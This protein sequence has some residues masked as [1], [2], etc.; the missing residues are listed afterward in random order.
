MSKKLKIII[1]LCVNALIVILGSI[2]ILTQIF[3]TNSNGALSVSGFRVFKYFTNDGNILTIIVSSIIVVMNILELKKNE[4]TKPIWAYYLQ[5][6]SAVSGMIIF[7]VVMF[8]LL[9][10]FGVGIILGYRMMVLHIINP[11]LAV[12]TLIL[13][14]EKNK[15]IS[16]KECIFGS[17]PVLVYGSIALILCITR[18]WEGDAIPYPF[19]R[20]YEQPWWASILYVCG[21]WGGSFGLGV[22]FNYLNT[23][24]KL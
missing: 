22:A 19:L 14:G 12:A 15:K 8:M 16:L 4:Y 21:I 18:V 13:F 23:K 17:A 5:L 2:A 24:F 3:A 11:L 7:L 6:A 10:V 9:P 1:S 20:V